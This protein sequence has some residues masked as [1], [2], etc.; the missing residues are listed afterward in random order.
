Y[1]L[2]DIL[3]PS[4]LVTKAQRGSFAPDAIDT[5]FVAFQPAV[6]NYNQRVAFCARVSGPGA[7]GGRQ[8]GVWSTAT[9]DGNLAAL[10]RT[11]DE[12]GGT[13]VSSVGSPIMNYSDSALMEGTLRG[14]GINA[15][16]NRF[17]WALEPGGPVEILRTGP[18]AVF[19]GGESFAGFP[20]FVQK[21]GDAIGVAYQ[22]RPGAGG[23]TRA[24][25]TGVVLMS[26]SGGT[27]E[28][29]AREGSAIPGGSWGGDQFGQ[30]MR[31]VGIGPISSTVIYGFSRLPAAGGS[32]VL[33]LVTDS[34]AGDP[35]YVAARG[36]AAPDLASGEVFQS[37][38]GESID[39]GGGTAFRA[40]LR[41]AGVNA[42]N[43]EGIWRSGLVAR[44]GDE[45]DSTNEPGVR[46]ARF[47]GVWQTDGQRVLFLAKLRGPGVT[48]ANDCALYLKVISEA[49]YQRL[50][51]EGEAACGCDGARV[52]VI[53]RVEVEPYDKSY[54]VVC[55]LA[56]GDRR[57]N[58]ALLGGYTGATAPNAAFR[59]PW[60]RLRKG[61]LTQSG[62]PH[63]TAIRSLTLGSS[64]DRTGFGAKGL[65]QSV[66]DVALGQAV[67]T[68]IYDNRAVEVATC[69][70]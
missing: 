36:D 29:L 20:Q 59:A 12:S 34:V 45:P 22:L 70:F 15:S 4:T 55:S 5:D 58:Q 9:S 48:P 69:I 28:N 8:K 50:V 56:G 31:R 67:L 32:P 64:Q 52:G 33:Q 30:F 43:N 7:S 2:R 1:S 38:L 25:D 42:G 51:R 39:A 23:T 44:K 49:G 13:R 6:I 65:A 35:L 19:G 18:T 21:Q 3:G 47:L 57:A 62:V 68:V 40:T 61:L 14:P 54:A 11:G 41:G 10:I 26:H 46:F 53:Q 17:L 27:L 66:N 37:F 24:S 60:M 63:T 16:N